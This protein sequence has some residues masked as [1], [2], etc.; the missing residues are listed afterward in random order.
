M[1]ERDGR[2]YRQEFSEYW[3][4]T[5]KTV[6]IPS[7]ETVFDYY[8]STESNTM[9][10]W[11]NSSYFFSLDYDSEESAMQ[12]VTVP[13]PETA[14]IAHWMEKLV[15]NAKPTMLVGPAGKSFLT[16]NFFEFNRSIN[17]G[18]IFIRPFNGYAVLVGT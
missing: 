6:R 14:S 11:K 13:T 12:S 8:L 1:A 17:R 3:R 9:E 4:K 2:D 7:R 15:M 18:S 10:Q 5:W 16:L